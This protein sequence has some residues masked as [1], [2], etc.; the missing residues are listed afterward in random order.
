MTPEQR[1][2]FDATGFLHVPNAMVPEELREARDA[3]DRLTST[4][5]EELPDGFTC[6]RL[7]SVFE[8]YPH[9][10]AYDKALER[11]LTHPTT[12]PI[13]MELTANKP[14]LMRGNLKVDTHE[15]DYLVLHS[16]REQAM[17]Y[18]L[19]FSRDIHW[20]SPSGDRVY[21]DFFNIF[22]YMDD[23]CPGDGGIL[24]LPGSHKNTIPFPDGIP[25]TMAELDYDYEKA[26][27]NDIL[28]HGLVN[29][30]PNAG[31]V[32]IASDQI[33]HGGMKWKPKDRKRRFLLLRY[34][35]QYIMAW[36]SDNDIAYPKAIL[37]RL[38]PQT[39]ELLVKAQMAHVK[40]IA[41]D[42]PVVLN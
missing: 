9:A 13:I 33:C 12:W 37:D 26:G 5:P 35:P 2:A 4:P 7:D 39:K 10:F 28:P 31:D 8:H 17:D 6:S 21:C 3:V 14:S 18:G 38:S 27:T 30:A 22:W 11:L 25:E 32:I 42:R 40:N 34:E 15:K 29:L 20:T 41:R 24:M 1:Y 23:V 19:G 16:I 36:R